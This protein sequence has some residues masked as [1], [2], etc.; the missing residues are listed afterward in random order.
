[1]LQTGLRPEPAQTGADAP[2]GIGD[3]AVIGDCRTAALIS[4]SGSIDWLC[5]PHF[6]GPS[7]F[8]ALLDQER[9]GRFVIRPAQEFRCRRRYIP[10]TAVLETTFQTAAGTAR[11]TDPMPIAVTDGALQPRREVLRILEGLEGEV[12]FDVRI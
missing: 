8:A 11:L 10:G 3:Y 7:A 9:G 5:L 6:S 4:R 12:A 1:M 2:A